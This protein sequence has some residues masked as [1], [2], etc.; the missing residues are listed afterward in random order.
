MVTWTSEGQDGAGYSVHAE[1]N[2]LNKSHA[3]KSNG[4]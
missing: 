4:I 3:S 2:L 1:K